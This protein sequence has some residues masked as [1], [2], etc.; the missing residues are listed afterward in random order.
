MKKTGKKARAARAAL[1]G[2]GAALAL[3]VGA[4]TLDGV[5]LATGDPNDT[6]KAAINREF[7][8][9]K[10]HLQHGRLGSALESFKKALSQTPNSVR[11]LNVVGI[12]YDKLGRSD[13]AERYYR[14]A[15]VVDP[16][17]AQT[18]NNFGYSLMLRGKYAEAL[19][20]LA[21]AAKAKTKD[22]QVQ[23]AARNYQMARELVQHGQSDRIER[24]SLSRTPKATEAVEK[25]ENCVIGPVWLEKSGERVYSLITEPTAVAQVA[26]KQLAEPLEASARTGGAVKCNTV[27]R[28]A[29]GAV[30]RLSDAPKRS[31]ETGVKTPGPTPQIEKAP[32]LQVEKAPPRTAEPSRHPGDDRDLPPQNPVAKGLPTVDV[33]NGAGRDKLAARVRIYLENRGL[34]VDRITNAESFDHV[35][36]T[37]YYRKGF[38]DAAK[39]YAE[40]LP[41]PAKLEPTENLSTDIRVRLGSDMLRVDSAGIL[42]GNKKLS[43][44]TEIWT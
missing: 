28:D 27:L 19:P 44:L 18:M 26:M 8:T 21:Q 3:G 35:T 32:T 30:P 5:S 37:V 10:D 17:S 40:S 33:S 20:F 24:A 16:E 38:V 34:T 2:F 12:S 43:F 13:I 23:I 14:R 39:R 36:T 25:R 29:Y 6:N 11:V 41:I 15:L 22:G 31:V 9:G 42:D 4:C 1:T 7:E